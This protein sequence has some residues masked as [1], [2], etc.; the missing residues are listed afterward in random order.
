MKFDP[1]SR[2]KH[3]NSHPSGVQCIEISE[4]LNFNL[5]NAF[6]YVF[7]HKEKLNPKEDLEKARWYLMRELSNRK[8]KKN[9]Y[10]NSFKEFIGILPTQFLATSK[11]RKVIRF[12]PDVNM[13]KLLSEITLSLTSEEA[14]LSSLDVI[15]NLIEKE[16]GKN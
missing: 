1:V 8:S 12:E 10:L 9:N 14:L 4:L 5:G 3:Y 16:Y 15:H 13:K 11:I 2:P 7:R 6:K